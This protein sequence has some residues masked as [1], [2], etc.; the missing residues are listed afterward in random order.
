MIA[1]SVL[2]SFREVRRHLLRSFLTVLGV[3]IGVFSVVTMVTLGNGATQSIKAS[4]SALGAD[5]LQV[6]PGQ[7]A[8]PGTSSGGEAVPAFKPSDVLALRTQ[9]AGVT[10]VA[11]QA[12]TTGAAI[13]NSQNWSTT[14]TGTTNDYFVAQKWALEQGRIFSPE[15]EQAGSS[16]CVIGSTLVSNLFQGVGAV[17]ESFRIKGV[18]C[19]VIGVLKSRGQG[20]FGGDQDDVVLMPIKAVQRQMT[21]N[22]DI[23]AIILGIDPDFDGNIIRSSLIAL[24]RERRG[25]EAEMPDNFSVLDAKQ[26]SDTVSGTVSILTLL[27]GAVAG[28]SLLV[29]GIGIMNIMLVS[30][31]E[32]TR[33][34]GTRL[35][36]GA[37]GDEVLLQFLVEAV[38]LSCLGGLIGIALA[39]IVCASAAP[40][41]GIPFLFSVEINLMSFGF[42]ALI[43]V[44]FGYFPARRAALLNPIEALRYE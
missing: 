10:A 14:I 20:G 23:R 6:R 32:R 30:V 19:Q 29:G 18:S 22:Q 1:V 35:A 28:V 25:L 33:E 4:I 5:L 40:L 41:M 17:G 15:E 38:V 26:I 24:L 7:S 13:R 36:I 37:L 44:V 34:I 9:L 2:L 11:A 31:T 39:F 27:V 42:S 3:V 16:V 43:G 8:G 21:G 12:Q